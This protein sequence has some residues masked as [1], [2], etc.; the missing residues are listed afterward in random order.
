M[1]YSN[2]PICFK[3][4]SQ[5]F[6]D[7]HH[8]IAVELSNLVRA[9][10]PCPPSDKLLHA[11]VQGLAI[12]DQSK[13][14]INIYKENVFCG[15]DLEFETE[16]SAIAPEPASYETA[17]VTSHKQAC[18][19][20]AFSYDGQLVATGSVDASIKIL[21]VERML[22][23]SAPEE[24]DTGRGEQQGHPVIRTLYDH[25]DEVSFLEFH[26]KE[27]ILA[28]GSRDCTVKLFDIS[29]ASVKKAHK[30]LSVS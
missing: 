8:S 11:V 21:D 3:N 18:R 5:L 13:E 7:G 29:K 22:A 25:T 27:P 20:G 28:S 17:Y 2:F 16:G 1:F 4:I 14:N 9:D 30:V 26:P 10:P 15:L 12:Q 24:N 23:K 19:A 6:Y